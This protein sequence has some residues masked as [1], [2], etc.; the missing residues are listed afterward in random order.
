MQ[1]GLNESLTAQGHDTQPTPV[2]R[3]ERGIVFVGGQRLAQ[4]QAKPSTQPFWRGALIMTGIVLLIAAVV[5]GILLSQRPPPRG[6][7]HFAATLSPAPT[8]PPV[9]SATPLPALPTVIQSWGQHAAVTTLATQLDADHLFQ[10][11][12]ITPDGTGLLGN[13]TTKSGTQVGIL[14]SFTKSFSAFIP[15]AS[16]K[17]NAP[18]CCLTDGHF[19]IVT[20]T[21][22]SGATCANCNVRY[23]V[24]DL[25]THV[26]RPIAIGSMFGGISGAWLDHGLL[27]LQTGTAGIQMIDMTALALTPSPL[28]AL[29]AGDPAPVQVAA[30]QWPDIVYFTAT[31]AL[32]LRDLAAVTDTALAA[33]LPAGATNVS[34]ALAGSTLFL[35]YA[36][37]DAIQVQEWDQFASAGAAPV[38]LTTYPDSHGT[39]L[40][41][42]DRIVT[43][44]GLYPFAWDRAEK[45][46]VVLSDAASTG[47][48]TRVMPAGHFLAV[49]EAPSPVAAQQI[50]IYDTSTLPTMGS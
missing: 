19:A 38:N 43:F 21:V 31:G 5:L 20:D 27:L 25:S 1:P 24:F 45:H 32:R 12:S 13:E 14:N 29:D 37:S 30:F 34:A 46:W 33:N 18:H 35:A 28:I 6:A 39:L 15:P 2:V 26:F 17:L 7:L 9:P 4:S 22:V 47:A 3:V 16:L 42:N 48:T 36:Q 40:A 49:S 10:A 50:T 23:S 8:T 41:A 44:A 11:T